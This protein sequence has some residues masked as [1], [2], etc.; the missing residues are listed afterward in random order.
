MSNSCTIN[1]KIVSDYL[2]LL[3]HI[4]RVLQVVIQ[5]LYWIFMYVD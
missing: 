1:I 3:T 4:F 2:T 5:I